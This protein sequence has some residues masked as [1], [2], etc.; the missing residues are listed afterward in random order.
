M[1]TALEVKRRAGDNRL[2]HWLLNG[3]SDQSKNHPGPHAEPAH[4]GRRHSWWRV[5][6]LTGVDYFSTLGYQP[7]IAA[8][9]AGVLS[10]VATLVLVALTLLGAL[11]V[12]RRVASESPRGEG[13]IA[14]LER[15]LSFWG[16]K[17]FVLVLLG[18]AATDFLITMTLSAADAT[19]H[20]VENPHVPELFHGHE[21]GITIALL[22]IL[23][24]VFLRGFTEAIGV[25]VG[26]VAVYLSLNVVVIA[27]SLWHVV[28]QPSL[29]TDWTTAL[30]TQHGNPLMMVAVSLLIFPKL[31]LG[32]SGFETGVAVMTHVDGGPD[33]TEERPI[34]R[35]AGTKKLLTSAAILMS[36]FLVSSSFV[37][38]LLIPPAE[39]ADGGSA[40]GR[41]LAYLAHGYLGDTFGTAYDLSTIAILWFAGASAMAGL[42]NLIPRYLPRYG[43][44]PT[45]AGAVRPLVLVLTGVAFLVTWLFDADVNAQGGAYA[46]GVLVL[47]TSAGIAVTLA[48]RRAGQRK[49]MVAFGVITAIFVYTTVANVIERPDGVKIAGL[50][51]AAILVI[52]FVSRLSRAFELRVTRVVLDA[53]AQ[54]FIRDCARR[55]VRLVA[56]EPDARDAREYAAKLAQVRHDHGLHEDEDVIFVEVTVTDA[57]DF[58]NVLDVHGEVLHGR[59]R[60]LTFE[61]ATVPN[62]LAAL[63]LHIRD[64][65]TR[66][67]RIYFEWTEGNPVLHFLRFLLFGVGEVAPMTREVLRRAEPDRAHR[68]HIIAG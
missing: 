62:A 30:T 6:C 27:V 12:Y 17:I 67:P 68:P 4:P 32:M 31:A 5:M 20:F 22:A 34:G 42:L 48:A 53:K 16:G 66:T 47:F 65:T 41:A 24:G 13:S 7:G 58:A 19:A 3:L 11:P 26:L 21:V 63:A 51:I 39:F 2:R 55:T 1:A 52:S 36:V 28:T 8:V 35:I 44:A 49:L 37:T 25:A 9:A 14:M 56:N 60:V 15:L 33:D 38:T 46:T 54:L 29:V 43:M 61:S 45:W 18:F 10:P 64:E 23:G 59:Y 57:S 40:S 50:F